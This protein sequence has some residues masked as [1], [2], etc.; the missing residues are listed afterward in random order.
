MIKKFVKKVIFRKGNNLFGFVYFG[1]MTDTNIDTSP[2]GERKMLE[3][4]VN[5]C[6]LGSGFVVDIGANDGF[7]NSST[8]GLFGR[9]NWAGLAI[10]MQPIK[11]AQL[12]Y[13]YSRF[14][15]VRLVRNRITPNNI[16]EILTGC[17]VPSA[18]DVLNID[19]DSY[20]LHVISRLLEEYQPK[21]ITME[22]NEKIPAGIFF[23]V[24]FDE[25]LGFQNGHF[26]GASIDAACK[27]VKPKGYLLWKVQYNNAFFV[28]KDIAPQSIVD[29]SSE[30]AWTV[31]Y[32]EK[33][34][35]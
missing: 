9:N 10:E 31:G 15:N 11:F 22:I 28:R 1:K 13:L 2:T 5:I 34:D 3:E 21:I 20:D 35:R 29:Q 24:N 30:V 26:F 8:L 18:F 33:K 4:I 19:I 14:L 17:E 12:A 27:I 7:S 23:A 6:G 25:N 16:C 32:K